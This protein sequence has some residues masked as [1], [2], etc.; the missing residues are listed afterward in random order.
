[1]PFHPQ[2]PY[3]ENP[4]SVGRSRA[5]SPVPGGP[6]GGPTGWTTTDTPG[7]AP[8]VVAPPQRPPEILRSVT[9]RANTD[10]LMPTWGSVKGLGAQ[11]WVEEP[12]ADGGTI[13]VWAINYGPSQ[14]VSNITLD[15]TTLAALGMIQGTDYNIYLGL[16]TQTTDPIATAWLGTRW[17]GLPY[18]TL[19]S[20]P[21]APF[22]TV[23]AALGSTGSQTVTPSNMTDIR[24]GD[25]VYVQNANGSNAERVTVTAVSSTTFTAIF[26]TTK[27]S[28]WQLCITANITY[29][30]AKFPK[31]GPGQ[32]QPNF[33]MFRCNHDGLLI[34][35]PLQD[36]TLT[37]KYFVAEPVLVHADYWTSHVYG[38]GY[39][40]TSI[41]WSGSVSAT[42]TLQRADIGGGVKRY[43][44][45]LKLPAKADHDTNSDLIRGHGQ[46]MK[47]VLNSGLWQFWMDWSQSPSGIVLTDS[48]SPP[49]IISAGP[50]RIKGRQLRPTRVRVTYPNPNGIAKTETTPANDDPLLA[51]GLVELVEKTWHIEGCPTDDQA[52]RLARYNRKSSAIDRTAPIR[53]TNDGVQIL[54]GIVVTVTSQRLHVSNAQC[55]VLSVANAD[56]S[57]KQSSAWDIVV[58]PYDAAVH[59][60]TQGSVT[61]T[62]PIAY[63]TPNV[64]PP[65][66]SNPTLTQEGFN[67]RVSFTAPS[68]YSFYARHRITV[69]E[70]QANGTVL[71]EYTLGEAMAGKDLYIKGVTMG[72]TYTVKAYIVNTMML[73]SLVAASATITPALAQIPPEVSVSANVSYV[74]SSLPNGAASISF[75]KPF[76]LSSTLYGSGSLT[77]T[78]LHS[79]TAANVN[80]GI[81]SAAC[82]DWNVAGA[83]RLAFNLGSAKTITYVWVYTSAFA[84]DPIIE[85]SNDGVTWSGGFAN[86]PV[87]YVAN[88]GGGVALRI[89]AAPGGSHQY[90][91]ITKASSLAEATTFTEV[92]PRETTATV[93]TANEVLRYN[94]YGFNPP[95]P[96]TTVYDTRQLYGSI[97]FG[98]EPTAS[99]P[100]DVN[101]I[102]YHNPSSWPQ[103]FGIVGGTKQINLYVT[104]VSPGGVES[105]G[106][107]FGVGGTF[108]ASGVALPI[109]QITTQ[110]VDI[111]SAA[112]T[113][114][115]AATGW[116]VNVTGTTTITSLG[117]KTA[118]VLRVVTFTG[119]LTLTHNATSLIL[120]GGANI[121]T[122]AGDVALFESLGSGNWRCLSFS[123]AAIPPLSVDASTLAPKNLPLFTG[124]VEANTAFRLRKDGGD[125]ITDGPY[126]QLLNQAGTR[127]WIFQLSG[128][129]HFDFRYFGGTSFVTVLRVD[130]GGRLIT[131]GAAPTPAI[132]AGG[133]TGATAAVDTGSSDFAGTVTITAGTSPNAQVTVRVTFSAALGTNPTTV[134]ITPMNGGSSWDRVVPILQTATTTK[135]EVLLDNNAVNLLAS[136]TYKFAYQVI[137]K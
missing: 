127:S 15:G 6:V 76:L 17:T 16:P 14:A 60:D 36:A 22:A 72:S 4:T 18:P 29:V 38:A 78:N 75:P 19:A 31:P 69:Q 35:D 46:G 59:D 8:P 68:T 28:G 70:T 93:A 9:F 104:T 34:Y 24:V 111:A 86:N 56:P 1:M 124:L 83:S 98:Q 90:L 63:S 106:L 137:G 20:I 101:A 89:Y 113:D 62:T 27:T 117:T 118:G 55:L 10:P 135:F 65:T 134:N 99:S 42:T 41:D 80:D 114:I 108:S 87:G 33:E 25:V 122:A 5:V 11:L 88:V 131:G 129:N 136:G 50:W 128:S 26:T 73:L 133:G 53:V 21:V 45:A 61:S 130:N 126:F 67:V 79:Y 96:L 116:E 7:P 3:G 102:A 71:T 109:D 37:T 43:Q 121:V 13:C 110:G 100:F 84:G 44:V 123:R 74:T 105:P 12:T 125:G 66:A 64:A 39:P 32:S 81:T 103:A 48:G 95:G 92:W 52:Q 47:P 57:S 85:T 54:P 51:S 132:I 107:M 49:N 30:I 91:G 23:T 77:A 58:Q 82:F 97:D 40:R 2:V 120:P 94:V 112:T 115:G 119:A